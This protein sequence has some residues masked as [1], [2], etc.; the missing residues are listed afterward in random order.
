MR[1]MAS[2]AALDSGIGENRS[3]TR[4][5]KIISET[6]TKS[7][8]LSRRACYV[9]SY[10]LRAVERRYESVD[11]HRRH[12]HRC[13]RADRNLTAALECAKHRALRGRALS[14]RYM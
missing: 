10:H 6:A 5:E 11:A 4:S 1:R 14:R 2:R 8:S 3:R 7:D 9:S 12:V 13:E